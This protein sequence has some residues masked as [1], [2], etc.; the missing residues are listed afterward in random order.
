MFG[1]LILFVL[2]A[3]FFLILD[4]LIFRKPPSWLA[5]AADRVRE[6]LNPP[7]PVPYDPFDALKVQQRLGALTAELQRLEGDRV[8]FAKAHRV[9]VAQS[10]YDAVLGEACQLAGVDRLEEELAGPHRRT[11]EELELAS[12]G[13]FW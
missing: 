2:P 11:R 3:A 5:A 7:P 9:R 13:W 4:A 6:R 12:R 8:M 10:A 1:I